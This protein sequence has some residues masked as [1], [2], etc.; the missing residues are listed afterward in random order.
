MV[1]T[2]PPNVWGVGSILWGAK[3]LHILQAKHRNI[4]QKQYCHEFNIV[5]NFK[6]FLFQYR[7]FRNGLY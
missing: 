5:M 2:L 7:P 4:K 1:K 3:N 6:F